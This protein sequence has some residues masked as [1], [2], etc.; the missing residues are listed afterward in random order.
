M[1][2]FTVM[3]GEAFLTVLRVNGVTATK[4]LILDYIMDHV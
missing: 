2:F 3:T 4:R 1:R